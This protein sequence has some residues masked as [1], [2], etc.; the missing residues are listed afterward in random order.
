MGMTLLSQREQEESCAAKNEVW[1]A[2]NE[3]FG[4]LLTSRT[5]ETGTTAVDINKVGSGMLQVL[6]LTFHYCLIS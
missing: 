3:V 6:F 2:A 1:S 5:A 4:L